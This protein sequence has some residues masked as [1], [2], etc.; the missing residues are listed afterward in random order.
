MKKI[1]IEVRIENNK[2]AKIVQKEGFDNSL[3]GTL[4]VIGLIENIKQ[5]EL[6]K[7]KT[8]VKEEY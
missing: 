7:L 3:S 1:T 2:M 4:E 8:F 5:K 6:E